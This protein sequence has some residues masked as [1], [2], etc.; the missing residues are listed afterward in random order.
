MSLEPW[1]IRIGNTPVWYYLRPFGSGIDAGPSVKPHI[2]P[3]NLL[4][5]FVSIA[6][7]I[8]FRQFRCDSVFFTIAR[9]DCLDFLT[10][11]R[12]TE[13]C[14]VFVQ[15]ENINQVSAA[16]YNT[17]DALNAI[18]YLFRKIGSLNWPIKKRVLRE[19]IAANSKIEKHCE[20]L[21]GAC[22]GDYF[23]NRFLSFIFKS[24][25]KVYYACSVVPQTEKFEHLLKSY[26]VQH[27]VIHP[28]H[29]SYADVPYVKNG[30]ITYHDIY[31]EILSDISYSGS[32]ETKSFRSSHLPGPES[33]EVYEVVIFTQP[34]SW[35]TAEVNSLFFTILMKTQSVR[36][37]KHPRDLQ[38]YDVPEH[39]FVQGL[40]PNQV[41][42]AILFTST[43]I[44]DVLIQKKNVII[45]DPKNLVNLDEEPIFRLYRRFGAHTP[46]HHCVTSEEVMSA[47]VLP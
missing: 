30:I 24:D 20:S 28:D 44:E 13:R 22:L 8:V 17:S 32:V 1:D 26:E 45:F 6:A 9:K 3:R 19:L 4:K 43:I 34:S 41:T 38:V 2:T 31:R 33:A 23:Y 47:L 27:G 11:V 15:Y 7:F 39:Y 35:T 21:I 18:R 42:N 37:Q 14:E 29:F 25:L 40:H 36:I 12:K 46:M 16:R 5:S 10:H